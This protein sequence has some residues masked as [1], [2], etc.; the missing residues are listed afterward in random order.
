MSEVLYLGSVL[1][2]LAFYALAG[3]ALWAL[4]EGGYWI[5]CKVTKK[6]Y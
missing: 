3:C 5:Y 1:A 6:T 4:V 2:A